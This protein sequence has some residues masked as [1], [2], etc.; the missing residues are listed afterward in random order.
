MNNR[1]PSGGAS[2]IHASHLP[3]CCLVGVRLTGGSSGHMVSN[4]IET[5]RTLK[6]PHMK[7]HRTRHSVASL[8]LEAI[9]LGFVMFAGHAVAEIAQGGEAPSTSGQDLVPAANGSNDAANR[10]STEAGVQRVCR[11]HDGA[12]FTWPYA[13]VPFGVIWCDS[14]HTL[15]PGPNSEG[16]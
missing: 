10:P 16:R 14:V 9:A 4:L 1:Q 7:R 6:D 2:P 13:N 8:R 12:E 15:R 11:T 3:F 5:Q